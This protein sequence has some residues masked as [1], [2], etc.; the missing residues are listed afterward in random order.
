[1]SVMIL[2]WSIWGNNTGAKL[3]GFINFEPLFPSGDG[4]MKIWQ[5]F[6]I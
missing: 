6:F 2:L 5:D 4:L 3:D 1:M